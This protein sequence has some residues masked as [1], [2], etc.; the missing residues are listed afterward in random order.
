MCTVYPL[1]IHSGR[2]IWFGLV[3]FYYLILREFFMLNIGVWY[4]FLL[5]LFCLVLDFLVVYLIV[6]VVGRNNFA[7]LK[8]LL[9]L[10][11]PNIMTVVDGRQPV[12]ELMQPMVGSS[13]AST[14]L[15]W[16]AGLVALVTLWWSMMEL[17]QPQ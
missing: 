9:S 7:F 12:A 17:Q 5:L 8:R 11:F 14:T 1:I 10:I 2:F 15:W 13:G 16:S 4:L 6:H 3:T